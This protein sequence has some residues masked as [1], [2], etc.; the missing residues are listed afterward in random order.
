MKSSRR[1]AEAAQHPG[2]RTGDQAGTGLAGHLEPAG[3]RDQPPG[4][5]SQ[6]CRAGRQLGY[7]LIVLDPIYK[8]YGNTD[9]NSASDVAALL[10]SIEAVAVRTGA[11]VAFG[12]HFSKGNQAGKNS[13]DR[14]SG[15]GVFARDPDSILNL[16]AHE[17]PDCFTLEATL[18]NFPP[19][20]PFVVKWD[21]PLFVRDASLNPADL[22]TPDDPRR[23]RLNAYWRHWGTMR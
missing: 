11:A 15:S 6:N 4:D 20:E 9:E 8:L 2:G 16:T 23:S 7:G 3:L 13:I 10:N 5:I 18:R 17:E 21:Y 12:T 14:V 19:M 22:K 1:S